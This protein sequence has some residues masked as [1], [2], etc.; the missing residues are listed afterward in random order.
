[1]LIRKNG[2]GGW[3]LCGFDW[4]DL[5]KSV[6]DDKKLM[7]TLYG[8]LLKLKDYEAIGLNPDGIDD[9][10]YKVLDLM[11]GCH[12]CPYEKGCKSINGSDTCWCKIHYFLFGGEKDGN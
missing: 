10:V 1:M 7:Q 5:P 2:K 8:A 4:D 11:H 6:R 9:I 12:N 3:S